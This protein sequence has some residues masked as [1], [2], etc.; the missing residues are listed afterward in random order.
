MVKTLDQEATYEIARRSHNWLKLKKVDIFSPSNS[1][2]CNILKL[3][4]FWARLHLYCLGGQSNLLRGENISQGLIP[5]WKL[6]PDL[7]HALVTIN[8]TTIIQKSAHISVYT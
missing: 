5:G 4:R 7:I 8:A 2:P 1:K 6:V 3:L